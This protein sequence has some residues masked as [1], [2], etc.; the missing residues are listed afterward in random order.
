MIPDPERSA[1][2]QE[3][4]RSPA[5]AL[6][7]CSSGSMEPTIAVGQSVRVRAIPSQ[8]LRVGD[9]VVYQGKEGAYI[10]HRIVL[11]LSLIH[12]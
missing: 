11:I 5:G 8:E 3:L 4:A 2:L 1:L 7:T 10:M 6:I 9:V 12:I